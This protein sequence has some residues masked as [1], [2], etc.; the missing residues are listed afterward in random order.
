MAQ[1][2]RRPNS[3]ILPLSHKDR[4]NFSENLA[5]LLKSAIPIGDALDSIASS[6]K[7]RLFKKAIDGMQA[8]IEAGYSL[9]ESLKRSRIVGEQTYS[10]VLLGEAS[11]NLVENLLIA[12]Q[13]EARRAAF[14]SKLRSAFI[15]P[16]IV[17]TLTIVIG[18]G[19]AWFLL[20]RLSDTFTQLH[21]DLP[22]ISKVL[23]NFGLFLQQ[24]GVVAVPIFLAVLFLIIYVLFIAPATKDIGKKILMTLP[25]VGK[26]IREIEIAQFGYLIG[27]LMDAGL[28]ITEAFRMLA[29]TSTTSSYKK[30]YEYLAD[31]IDNG[32]TIKSS[33]DAYK[34]SKKLLPPS[35]RQ[36]IMAGE[37]SGSLPDVLLTIGHSYE[38]KSDTTTQNLETIIEPILLVVIA[39]GVMLVAVA[40]ILPIYSLIGGLNQ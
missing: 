32:H 21:V 25:G 15:Y 23:I 27:T 10:L 35:V 6:N 13:Q 2:T 38:Q 17:I 30:L 37:R 20:P 11:G 39:G 22:L 9:A 7:S 4:E 31:S 1:K 19:V 24:H 34:P 5:L 8:D 40:V 26:L 29:S 18:L 3:H 14:I 33:L 28:N 36:I 16:I 12:S